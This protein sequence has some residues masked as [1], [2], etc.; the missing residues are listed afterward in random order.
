[1]GIKTWLDAEISCGRW[2]VCGEGLSTGALAELATL[3]ASKLVI[4]KHTI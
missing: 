3:T 4:A 1:M 2:Q